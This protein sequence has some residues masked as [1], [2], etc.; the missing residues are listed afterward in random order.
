MKR[1]IY[2]I[3]A[4]ILGIWL[5]ISTICCPPYG[6]PTDDWDDGDSGG[7]GGWNKTEDIINQ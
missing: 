2:K 1:I 4:I 3:L 5:G 7:G 6:T